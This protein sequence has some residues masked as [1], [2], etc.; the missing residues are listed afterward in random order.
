MIQRGTAPRVMSVFWMLRGAHGL[1][2]FRTHVRR[3][4]LTAN[5]WQ[6]RYGKTFF[7]LS[8]DDVSARNPASCLE[9]GIVLN[10]RI[11]PPFSAGTIKRKALSQAISASGVG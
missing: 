11:P 4:S 7:V 8:Q 5:T 6:V 9:L 3:M 2:R 1:T 10:W